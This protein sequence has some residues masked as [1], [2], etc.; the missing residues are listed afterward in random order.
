MNVAL[1]AKLDKALGKLCSMY[2]FSLEGEAKAEARRKLVFE[3]EF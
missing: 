3:I 1:A 2:N